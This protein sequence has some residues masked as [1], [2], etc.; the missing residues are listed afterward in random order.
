MGHSTVTEEAAAT[1][2]QQ[3]SEGA[4]TAATTS[5]ASPSI[6]LLLIDPLSPEDYLENFAEGDIDPCYR[7]ICVRDP[8][9]FKG[10]WQLMLGGRSDSV[11]ELLCA[12][13]ISTLKRKVIASFASVTDVQLVECSPQQLQLQQQQQQQ[14][15]QQQGGEGETCIGSNSNSSSAAICCPTLQLTTHLPLRNK[16]QGVFCF[17]GS[18]DRIDDSD[19]G[20]WT[21]RCV[22]LHG[23]AVQRRSN[24]EA[25]M[26]D[27]RQQQQQLLLMKK[28]AAAAAAAAEG[29]AATPPADAGKVHS[30]SNSCCWRR[31]QDEQLLLMEQQLQQQQL[32]LNETATAAAAGAAAAGDGRSSRS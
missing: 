22:W 10:S 31:Q 9:A 29:E 15:Q 4:E 30:S 3:K 12:L 17:D 13:G 16:K 14:L 5:P 32:L 26:W 21:T 1:M 20:Q 2:S 7:S 27:T 18:C 23:R 19:T 6:C 25:V 24:A 11:E 28:T 8:S